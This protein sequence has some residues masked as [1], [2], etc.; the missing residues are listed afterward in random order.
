MPLAVAAETG[1]P[2]DDMRVE[3]GCG[4]TVEVQAKSGLQRGNKL[5]KATLDL[6]RG[7]DEDPSLHSV[8]LVMALA[9]RLRKIYGRTWAG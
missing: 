9:A 3:C 7:L 8:L 1:G 2:G 6:V 5:W 4:V